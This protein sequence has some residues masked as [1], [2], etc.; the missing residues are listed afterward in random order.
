ML[1]WNCRGLG[2][3]TTVQHIRELRRQASLD[4]IFV[5]ETKNSDSFVLK[6]LDFMDTDHHCW[7]QKRIRRS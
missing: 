5:M 7:G 4:I 2:N 6:E 1:S 3:P